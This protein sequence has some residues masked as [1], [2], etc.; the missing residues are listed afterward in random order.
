MAG[1][2]GGVG[3]VAMHSVAKDTCETIVGYGDRFGIET[4]GLFGE[5]LP[6]R[7]RSESDDFNFGG[8]VFSNGKRAAAD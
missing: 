5:P 6:V 8:E 2:H 4:R 7:V 1:K 3:R